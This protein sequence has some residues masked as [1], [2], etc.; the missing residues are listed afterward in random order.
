V[1]RHGSTNLS[2]KQK[3]EATINL[4]GRHPLMK[5]K[6]PRGVRKK[7]VAFIFST[8][9]HAVVITVAELND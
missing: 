6:V 3:E 5:V 8:N 2:L 7:T 4:Y 9:I 1:L